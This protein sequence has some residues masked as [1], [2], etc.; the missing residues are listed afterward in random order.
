MPWSRHPAATG[1][2]LIRKKAHAGIIR[3]EDVKTHAEGQW[4][5]ASF[6][7]GRAGDPAGQGAPV[8]PA[9]VRLRSFS[10]MRTS[11][12]ADSSRAAAAGS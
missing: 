8:Q 3:P 12:I 6:G 5:Y 2:G 11:A 4:Q 9:D 1:N 10:F 7:E